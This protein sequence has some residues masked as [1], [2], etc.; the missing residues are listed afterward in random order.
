MP[1]L[2]QPDQRLAHC[3]AA[4]AQLPGQ[5]HF[6]IQLHARRQHP[7]LDLRQKRF[8]DKKISVARHVNNFPSQLQFIPVFCTGLKILYHKPD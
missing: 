1:F 2:L 8:V 4:D 5:F 7:L 3:H 6:G